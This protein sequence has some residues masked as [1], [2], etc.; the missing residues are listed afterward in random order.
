M[1]NHCN[2]PKKCWVGENHKICYEDEL[3]AEMMAKALRYHN[4][5]LR[6]KA[7]KCEFGDHWHLAKEK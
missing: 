2:L 4:P 1:K 5:G 6:L 3:E 7:Y